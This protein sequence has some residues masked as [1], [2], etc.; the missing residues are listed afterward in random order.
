V[1][2]LD[3][4]NNA[5]AIASLQQ[6]R[7]TMAVFKRLAAAVVFATIAASSA[8]AQFSEPATFQAQHPDRDVLNDGA[9]TP[10]ARGLDSNRRAESANANANVDA[11][12]NSPAPVAPHHQPR[13][14]RH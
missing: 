2:R 5:N 10:E 3:H 1:W 12:V 6:E 4:V 9:L 8:S 14:S 7:T 11:S 13:R